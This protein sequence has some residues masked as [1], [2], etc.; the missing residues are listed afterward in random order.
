MKS[1]FTTSRNDCRRGMTK[2]RGELAEHA[3]RPAFMR[4]RPQP[5]STS[6]TG[7][8]PPWLTLVKYE[9]VAWCHPKCGFPRWSLSSQICTRIQT[10]L[11]SSFIGGL[12]AAG[13]AGHRDPFQSFTC[14]LTWR[15]AQSRREQLAVSLRWGEGRGVHS[16]QWDWPGLVHTE[17]L[18]C[19]DCGASMLSHPGLHAFLQRLDHS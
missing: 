13:W 19:T 17:L 14:S 9:E 18:T 4:L 8:R 1:L 12:S 7:E 5:S 15:R 10:T 2:S 11:H 6:E 3:P 16:A